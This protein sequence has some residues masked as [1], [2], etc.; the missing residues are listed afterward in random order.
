MRSAHPG[1][2][3]HHHYSEERN[4]ETARRSWR[5]CAQKRQTRNIRPSAGTIA[6]AVR[7]LPKASGQPQ[8]DFGTTRQ[9]RTKQ[10]KRK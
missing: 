10:P 8:T 7:A 6:V 2:W 1:G 4:H 9:Y 3:G 5:I